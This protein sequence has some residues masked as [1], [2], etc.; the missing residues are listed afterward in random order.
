MTWLRSGLVFQIRTRQ[1]CIY[2][3]LLITISLSRSTFARP[4]MTSETASSYSSEMSVNLAS[5]HTLLDSQAHPPTQPLMDRFVL[6]LGKR[7]T[8]NRC[9]FS[10]DSNI[11]GSWRDQMFCVPICQV[12]PAKAE[13]W[14]VVLTGNLV[15]R[16][17]GTGNSM[18]EWVCE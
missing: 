3:R 16:R 6:I 5:S 18:D 7:R 8:W 13:T 10:E 17:F 11:R 9:T 15:Y 1:Y 4:S 12:F 14:A 2:T